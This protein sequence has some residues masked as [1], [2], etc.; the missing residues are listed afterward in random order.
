MTE[1]PVRSS[2]KKPNLHIYLITIIFSLILFIGIIPLSGAISGT[3]I[4]GTI[5]IDTTWTKTGSPYNLIGP[6]TVANGATLTIEPGVAIEM[7]SYN[8]QI[9]GNL[10]AKGTNQNII[11]TSSG[12]GNIIFSSSSQDYNQATQTGCILQSASLHSVSIV[13]S[14]ASPKICDCTITPSYNAVDESAISITGGAA[15][16]I[17]E[18]ILYSDIEMLDD[19][20]PTITNNRIIGGIYG[21]GQL[22][23]TPTIQN[24]LI[25][26]GIVHSS[27]KGIGIIAS[28]SYT[29]ITNN[30]I[31]NC[32]TAIMIFDGTSMIRQNIIAGNKEAIRFHTCNTV[33]AQI[34]NNLIFNNTAGLFTLGQKAAVAITYNTLLNNT[35]YTLDIAIPSNWWGTTDQT[36]IAKMIQNQVN[37]VPFLTTSDPKTPTIPNGKS[38]P[39]P[40]V[41][42]SPT[43]APPT[44]PTPTLI[45]TATPSPIPI[46]TATATPSPTVKPTP[47]LTPTPN[48]SINPTNTPSP[49]PS[50][51]PQATPTSSINQTDMLTPTPTQIPDTTATNTPIPLPQL[52][53]P[54]NT[55]TT[56]QKPIQ[57]NK[58]QFDAILITIMLIVIAISSML[59]IKKR[60][61]STNKHNLFP[62]DF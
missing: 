6:V 36:E 37:F 17:S 8:I 38:Y 22:T 25:E 14:G 59:V 23:H 7:D 10:N 2:I 11:I 5:N 40:A 42:T 58:L 32:D 26:K 45:P 21:M 30:T 12:L 60:F 50:S 20:Q 29:Y 56:I 51:T 49:T 24:N 57:Q 48:A 46:P 27:Y 61:K 19:A 47:I 55:P 28:G 13:A 39:I 62:R 16:T 3:N 4:E 54:I 43:P 34:Q 53:E 41:T 18:N 15:P 1:Y 31:I 33:S 9:N 44:T 52:N 35:Q